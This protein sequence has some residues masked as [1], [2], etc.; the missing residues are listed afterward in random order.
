MSQNLLIMFIKNS[1]P[2]KVKERLVQ[3]IGNDR[4][5][6]V[7]ISMLEHIRKVTGKLPFDKAVYYSDFIETNDIFNAE[8]YDKYL[9]SGTDQPDKLKNAF[10]HAFSSGYR[11]VVIICSD[12]FELTHSH[13]V[14]AFEA[15]RDVDTVL[16][17]SADGGLYLF[18]MRKFLP[19]VFGSEPVDPDNIFLDTLLGW[20][21]N[22]I[23]FHLLETLS[24]INTYSDL[25]KSNRF[26]DIAGE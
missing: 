21:K 1:I 15:L 19:V 9:Q 2:G 25:R 20:K 11:R 14:D 10:S 24:D 18:G 13:V 23:S 4:A 17:P 7:Y 8:D 12:C 3:D 6:D 5:L 26:P 16:G 22:N